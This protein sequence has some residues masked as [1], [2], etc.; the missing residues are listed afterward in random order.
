MGSC[1]PRYQVLMYQGNWDSICIWADR[2]H[3]HLVEV[4]I[5]LAGSDNMAQCDSDDVDVAS[6][7]DFACVAV[8]SVVN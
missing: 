6:S 8:L 5:S 7:D 2:V 1:P 3:D 4:G